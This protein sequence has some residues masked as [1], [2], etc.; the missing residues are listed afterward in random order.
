MII[1]VKNV[2]VVSGIN[3]TEEWNNNKKGLYKK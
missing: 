3:G 2:I 1:Y